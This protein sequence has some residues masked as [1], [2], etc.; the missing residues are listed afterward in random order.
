MTHR[1][2][3]FACERHTAL[4]FLERFGIPECR[5][6]I[7]PYLSAVLKDYLEFRSTGHV[8]TQFARRRHIAGL[9]SQRHSKSCLSADGICLIKLDLCFAAVGSQNGAYHT[10][11]IQIERS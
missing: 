9:R 7:E 3:C 11:L 2:I 8:E 1:K 10:R 6:R 4:A 5:L